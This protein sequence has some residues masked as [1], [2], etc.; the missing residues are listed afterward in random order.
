M[1]SEVSFYIWEMSLKVN[2][3]AVQ[4]RSVILQTF[5]LKSVFTNTIK[6]YLLKAFLTFEKYVFIVRNKKKII[7]KCMKRKSSISL[8][9]RS[10]YC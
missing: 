9:S 8:P 10:N 2:E 6:V 4:V 1:P 3:L 5:Y 7:Q